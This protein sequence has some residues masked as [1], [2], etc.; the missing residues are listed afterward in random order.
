MTSASTPGTPSHQPLEQPVSDVSES[1]MPMLTDDR[2]SRQEEDVQ[3]CDLTSAN[4]AI[5]NKSVSIQTLEDIRADFHRYLAYQL[6]GH[7][8]RHN[9]LQRHDS[10]HDQEEARNPPLQEQTPQAVPSTTRAIQE[11]R[12]RTVVQRVAIIARGFERCFVV[13]DGRLKDLL[14]GF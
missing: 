12:R 4:T 10:P 7:T 14:S 2:Q 6:T 13:V 11:T 3:P 1:D 9:E 5:S 8:S